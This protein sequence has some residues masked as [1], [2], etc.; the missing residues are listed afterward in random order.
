MISNQNI[1]Q[2]DEDEKAKAMNLAMDV[3]LSR[4]SLQEIIDL[5]NEDPIGWI[6]ILAFW[7][8]ACPMTKT[9]IDKLHL[10]TVFYRSK[11]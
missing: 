2:L 7:I 10:E 9:I 5:I 6:P 4:Y 8:K 3:E 1:Y 11:Q